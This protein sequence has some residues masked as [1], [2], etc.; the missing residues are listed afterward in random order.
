VL[1]VKR[2][3]VF[4]P[5][6]YTLS[7]V[8]TEMTANGLAPVEDAGVWRLNEEMTGW[9]EAR[10]DRNG[11]YELRGLYAG[12]GEVSV[13]KDGYDTAK[14]NVTIDGDTR[15]DSQLVRH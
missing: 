8:V 5:G 7:S 9:Q 6:T 3:T 12:G 4:A 11:F 14:S 13:I 10:T 2:T 1:V 15:F